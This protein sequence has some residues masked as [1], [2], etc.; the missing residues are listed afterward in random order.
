[1]KTTL[2]KI[3]IKYHFANFIKSLEN[4]YDKY[5]FDDNVYKSCTYTEN[6]IDYKYVITKFKFM[7]IVSIDTV[8]YSR[9][10]TNTSTK[11]YWK[12]IPSKNKNYDTIINLTNDIDN[13]NFIEQLNNLPIDK[14]AVL[15]S[16]KLNSLKY[17]K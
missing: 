6:K 5:Y 14:E 11:I 13:K 8:M 12:I 3:L 15:R 4:D 17:G 1:M 16:L 7:I 2:D 9:A 10:F